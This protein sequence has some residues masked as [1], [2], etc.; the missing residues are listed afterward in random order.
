M[1]EEWFRDKTVLDIGCNT[2]LLTIAVASLF[3]PFKITG[4]DIDKKLIRMAWKNLY[5]GRVS[6]VTPAGQPF[7]KSLTMRY[8]PPAKDLV[9]S[10]SEVMRNIEFVEVRDHCY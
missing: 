3:S 4:I 8:L 10:S 7:P 1:Q 5:R 2:G 6:I 9:T